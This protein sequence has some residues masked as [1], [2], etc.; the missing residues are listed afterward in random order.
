MGSNDDRAKAL[1]EDEAKRQA[2]LARE[3]ERLK[4][5]ADEE[6]RKRKHD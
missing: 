4:R 3:R 5:I 2:D 1:A 6:A